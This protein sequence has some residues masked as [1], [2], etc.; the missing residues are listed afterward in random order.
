VGKKLNIVINY[1]YDEN[2]IGGTYYI[3]NL[4]HA[5]QQLNDAEKP[6]LHIKSSDN[7]AVEKL[8]ILTQYPYLKKF[9]PYSQITKL[10]RGINKISKIICKTNIFSLY[11]TF[12]LEFPGSFS[13]NKYFKEKLFW[14][15][16]FQE[17]YLPHFFSQEEIA[18]RNKAYEYIKS[19][20]KFVL[21]SSKDAKKDFNKY[22]VN[23][24]PQQFVLNFAT[25]HSKKNLPEAET[26]LKKFNINKPYFLCS[27]Q[28]WAHK[29]HIVILE[30]IARLK[31]EKIEILVVFT[32]KENDYRNPHYFTFL[33]NIVEK[34]NIKDNVKFLGFIDRNDQIVL[35]QNCDSII[36]PSLF[37]GWSTVNE[38]AKAEN[39][40]IFCSDLDVNKE[41]LKDYPN[42][43]FFA[44][45]DPDN[46][47][48]LIKQT[49]LDITKIDYSKNLI[50]F[51]RDFLNIISEIQK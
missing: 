51:G 25:Y 4:I 7:D 21:F 27:N 46:L 40:Y 13:E 10:Q 42:K 41:Q 37:E 5:L 24:K 2:W 15:P 43:S 38:D 1:S 29:N 22:Y 33:C 18:A 26:V 23:G 45:T 39:K 35:L 50:K 32:G 36:Q 20:S 47:A 9:T 3:Q 34:L 19:N 6:F 30:T 11:K 44:A 49:T 14:I 8:Y 12:D 17:K 48:M 28:F 31:N 16:D